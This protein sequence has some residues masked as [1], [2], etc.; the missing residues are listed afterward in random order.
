MAAVDASRCFARKFY[1]REQRRLEATLALAAFEDALQEHTQKLRTSIFNTCRVGD[2]EV[3]SICS[4]KIYGIVFCNGFHEPLHWGCTGS[5]AGDVQKTPRSTAAKQSVKCRSTVRTQDNGKPQLWLFWATVCFCWLDGVCE[6][7][8]HEND[9]PKK[10]PQPGTPGSDGT[11]SD[12]DDGVTSSS[13]AS[14]SSMQSAH[15]G[16]AWVRWPK[17]RDEVFGHGSEPWHDSWCTELIFGAEA[18][19][20]Q[21]YLWNCLAKGLHEQCG[22]KTQSI[23]SDWKRRQRVKRR[24]QLAKMERRRG[25]STTFVHRSGMSIGSSGMPESFDAAHSQSAA[26]SVEESF[27]A[28]TSADAEDSERICT[29]TSAVSARFEDSVWSLRGGGLEQSLSCS[30]DKKS[31]SSLEAIPYEISVKDFRSKDLTVRSQKLEIQWDAS[32]PVPQE[33]R[34]S[35]AEPYHAVETNG[36]GACALHSVF[37]EPSAAK[38]LFC[39]RARDIAVQ[40]L[41]SLPQAAES[42][43]T[44]ANLFAC[45]KASFWDE[46]AKPLL[47]KLP[48]TEGR[49]FWKALEQ[50]EPELA[51]DARHHAQVSHEHAIKA[52]AAKKRMLRASHLFFT[53]ENEQALIKPVAILLGYINAGTHVNIKE[54]GQYRVRADPDSVSEEEGSQSAMT[55]DGFVRGFKRMP[56][57]HDGP[58][59]KYSALFDPRP[60][61]DSLRE[62]FLVYGDENLAATSFLHLMDAHGAQ[63][64]NHSFLADVKEWMAL[65]SPVAAP[66][67]FGL[68]SWNAYLA[69]IGKASYY[70]S[71]EEL[72]VIC[73]LASKRVLIF[74]ETQGALTLAGESLRGQGP[75]ITI[76]LK[77]N[78]LQR[79][80]THFERIVPTSMLEQFG[81]ARQQNVQEDFLQ[82]A[83]S[84]HQA[85]TS[86]ARE[87]S[88][89]LHVKND[90]MQQE[91]MIRD[92][93]APPPPPTPHEVPRQDMMP[94]HD[95]PQQDQ[96]YS[97]RPERTTLTEPGDKHVYT[98]PDDRKEAAETNDESLGQY[99]VRCMP[100]AQSKDPRAQLES[101]LIELASELR[102]HPTAPA[103]IV[104]SKEPTN[105]VFQDDSA[106]L[107]PPKHCAFKGCN[108]ALKWKSLEV[109]DVEREREAALMAHVME[110]HRARVEPVATKL[111]LCNSEVD[112]FASAYNEA[113]AVKVRQGA[114]LASFAIDRKCLRKA[115]DAMA[116][117]RIQSL[118]C[119]FCACVHPHMAGHQNQQTQYRRPFN[120]ENEDFFFAFDAKATQELLSVETYLKNYG[121][122]P[123]GFFDL[124]RHME[125]FDDWFINVPVGGNSV[126]ILCCPEDRLC[127]SMCMKGKTLCKECKVPVCHRCWTSITAHTPTL[128]VASLCN[129]MM[130][131]YA[132]EELYEDGGLTI[133]EMICA[134]PCITSMI[135]FS[136]EVKYGNM[137]DSTLHMQRHRVGA[138][139]NATTF[140][141]PWDNLLLELQRLESA[142]AAQGTSLDLPRS[143]KDLA[144]VVQILLKTNDEDQRDNLKNFIFQAQVDRR[145]VVNLILSMK[146][147]GH[148]AYMRINE[149]AVRLKAL[150]LPEK[151]VPPELISL[152]PNDNTLDKMHIQKAATPVEGL[153]ATPSES[154][155]NIDI[156]RPNAVVLEGSGL[157]EG[158]I[159]IR[160][161]VA[162]HSLAESLSGASPEGA[163]D[164]ADV[165]GGQSGRQLQS[166]LIENALTRR[167]RME[168][169]F[170]LSCC[171]LSE[172][173]L[174]AYRCTSTHAGYCEAGDQNSSDYERG[175]RQRLRDLGSSGNVTSARF[176]MSSGS[177]MQSQFKPWYFGV[178]FAFLFK[179]CTGT[180]HSRS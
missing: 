81:D 177:A 33:M 62:A 134:S 169:I 167:L 168:C 96:T 150:Q 112:R 155:R 135:C 14:E 160:R 119:F 161:R 90:A 162:I 141:L 2:G 111:P 17:T 40:Y 80:R 53:A 156:A 149:D 88:Q 18:E 10:K 64:G 143:G 154:G 78:N 49:L 42:D 68:R 57:P 89:E 73:M 118:I 20:K 116:G 100:C 140:L 145:K 34:Q 129:D 176:A 32:D 114:P 179:F 86:T 120:P 36:D 30:S 138:R 147:R 132:P 50:L 157:D 69:C 4:S 127:T 51:M 65:A 3:C 99:I 52:D 70:F 38:E 97:A 82:E 95:R 37:G 27:H 102:E 13:S 151:G 121:K 137:F 23:P 48:T 41:S 25:Q 60:I 6:N 21:S 101:A 153:T 84:L 123:A 71:V 91:P 105:D 77:A 117:D 130:I 180:L 15:R 122:D 106:P 19:S 94:P 166:Q 109:L 131:F 29:P 24:L 165:F 115:A 8:S 144:Y 54:N 7:G 128:P 107:L 75:L 104:D 12:D 139:G 93:A 163:A 47:N 28:S 113:I 1:Q 174:Y 159:K 126:S 9:A 58:S 39:P 16:A 63:A 61:F 178:A 22:M 72:K 172:Q 158:D 110:A 11:S 152:L 171:M 142:E 146:R 87:R 59:C 46:F 55:Q 170:Q 85:E 108:W 43:E 44:A 5:T 175:V 76:K 148:R 83:K 26:V 56:F 45:I 173:D 125:E 66:E 31:V 74:K 164:K 67:N 35:L 79:V 124:G 136:M 92:T 98:L 103:S 133:M